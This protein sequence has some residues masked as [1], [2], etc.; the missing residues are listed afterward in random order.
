MLRARAEGSL[1]R[2]TSDS[3]EGLFRD[4]ALLHKHEVPGGFLSRLRASDLEM[5]YR[6]QVESPEAM[7]LAWLDA[8]GRC[9]G[10]VS[11]STNTRRLYLWVIR[12]RWAV[13]FR[14]LLVAAGM[15]AGSVTNVQ[16]WSET[17]RYPFRKQNR[18]LPDAEILNLA[19]AGTAIRQ[20]IASILLSA[21]AAE[22][23]ER[24]I[25]YVKAVT[26]KTQFAAQDFYR[27]VGAEYVGPLSIH[28]E[29]PEVA[30][31]IDLAQ[32]AVRRP[33]R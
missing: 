15:T 27:S 13:A 12:R 24:D 11:V 2:V 32:V 8:S 7:T 6:A 14:I 16:R 20:G 26:G 4:I 18:G 28:A 3:P 33:P 30:F 19:V 5:L 17:V 25:R 10:Y 9:V 23:A 22:L 29:S 31:V 1:L 21:V